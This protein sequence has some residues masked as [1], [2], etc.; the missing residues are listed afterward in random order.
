LIAQAAG[1]T[2]FLDEIGDLKEASQIKLL[3]LL[4][5]GE[6]FPLGSDHPRKSDA[7][8]VMATHRNLTDMMAKDTF[9]QDLYYRLFAHQVVIPPLRERADD[10]PLLLEHYL[11]VAAAS[12][13]KKNPTPPPELCSYLQSYRFPG[14]VR[15]LKALVYEAVTRHTQG[16]LSMEVF[17]KA[18]GKSIETLPASVSSDA[19]I[20]LK[21]PDGER[22][23][24][25]D[26]A[27]EILVDQAMRMAKGNQGIAAGHLGINRS[28]LNK[29]LLKRKNT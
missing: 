1:G 6:Y 12:L 2:L 19:K 21:T 3:R 20:I 10:I 15:E 17:L 14:N 26:E 7:R 23:P 8:I 27:E 22:M 11:K 13:S 9:R 4:Q 16:V 29:K 28:A 5:E 25:L 18:M 24:T